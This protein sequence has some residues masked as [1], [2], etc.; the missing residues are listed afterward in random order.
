M[1]ICPNK[2]TPNWRALN[3]LVPDLSYHIWNKLE[4]N[5]DEKGHPIANNELFERIL[6][7]N[8]G[9]YKQSY[10][11]FINQ[12]IPNINYQFKAV[13][14]IL[15]NLN[16][17]ENWSKQIKDIDQLF[18]KIQK[19]LGIPKE[20]I[21]LIKQSE[22]KNI[23]EKLLDFISKYSYTVE[24]NL[25]TIG[26]NV[27]YNSLPKE[28]DYA[29]KH[30]YIENGKYYARRQS[31]EVVEI[32]RDF[33]EDEQE[34]WAEAN[35]TS[36]IQIPTQYYSNL[37]V[38]GG[39]NYTEN[40]ISTP[41]ITP[42]IKGHAQ[43][44]TGNGIGWFRS[45][46]RVKPNEIK[47]FEFKKGYYQVKEGSVIDYADIEDSIEDFEDGKIT[48]QQL[49]DRTGLSKHP[50]QFN[51]TL[52]WSKTGDST[53][54][55]RI[56][57]IQ[58][59][60]FQKGRDKES[61]IN[62]PYAPSN[63]GI[64]RSTIKEEL[65]EFDKE[66]GTSYTEQNQFLQLL[67][68]DNNWVTFFIKSIIQDSAKKGY[69]KVLFPKGETAAKVEGHQTIADEIIKINEEI[70]K[71]SKF[72]NN[73]SLEDINYFELGAFFYEK[74]KVGETYLYRTG[75]LALDEYDRNISKE[76]YEEA[77][78]D[79]NIRAGGV[80]NVEERIKELEQ[81]KAELKSQGIE[82]LKPIEA[83]YEIRVQNILKKLGNTKD[84]TDEYGN[85]WIEY[86]LS[87]E[88]LK[89]IKFRGL[90]K[91][92]LLRNIS[93]RIVD[94]AEVDL[95]KSTDKV[96]DELIQLNPDLKELLSKIKQKALDKNLKIEQEDRIRNGAQAA[97]IPDFNL[98]QT[99][100]PSSDNILH[101]L[102]H[103]IT[104]ESWLANPHS[105]YW[106]EVGK[107]YEYSLLKHP[108]LKDNY[109]FTDLEEF[110]SEV[111]ANPYLQKDLLNTELK[112]DYNTLTPTV[113]KHLNVLDRLFAM[114]SR[115]VHKFLD[116]KHD[117]QK[118]NVYRT[119]ID[120]TTKQFAEYNLDISPDRLRDNIKFRSLSES[121]KALT[122]S[123]SELDR[124]AQL[125]EKAI[126]AAR[127]KLVIEQEVY[128][129][130]FNEE[131][132]SART[133]FIEKMEK[134]ESELALITYT[135]KAY[136]QTKSVYSKYESVVKQLADI[137]SGKSKLLRKDIFNPA[138]L[139]KWRDYLAAY[140]VIDEFQSQLMREGRLDK[141]PDVKKLLEETIR[142]KNFI[143]DLYRIEGVNMNAEFQVKYY[144]QHRVDLENT[145][146]MEYS[147]LPQDQKDKISEQEFI[148]AKSEFSKESI[149]D[150]TKKNLRQESIRA[151]KDINIITRYVSSP[152][153]SKNPIVASAA[154]AMSIQ[155]FKTESE[156]LEA[157]DTIV[158][159][160]RELE[161]QHGPTKNKKK[162]YEHMIELDSNNKPTGN[163]INKFGGDFWSAYNKFKD[164]LSEQNLSNKEFRDNMRGW[165]NQN[166][167]LKNKEFNKARW[168]FIDNLKE[169]GKLSDEE[170]KTLEW[171]D[172]DKQ[173]STMQ[174]LSEA[175]LLN[176]DA[177]DLISEW[178]G[179]NIWEFREPSQ[180]WKNKNPQWNKLSQILKDS[181]DPR[182]KY[183]NMFL[184]QIEKYNDKLP[185]NKRLSPYQIPS[186]IRTT[187]DEIA[188]GESFKKIAGDIIHKNL[189]IFV[190]DPDRP[191]QTIIDEQGN[192]RNLIPIRYT[193]R[194]SK[195]IILDETGKEV[196]SFRTK[197]SAD[198]YLN[199]NINKKYKLQIISTPEE[200]SYDLSTVLM[201]FAHMAN[202]YANKKEVLAEMELT[203]FLIDNMEVVD[204]DTKGNPKQD[205]YGRIALKKKESIHLAN[206]FNDWYEMAMY[207]IREKDQGKVN[208]LGLN[209]D[210]N[211]ATSLLNRITSLNVLG[212]NLRAA[213][214]ITTLVE[215]LQIGEA[216]A[217]QYMNLKSYHKGNMF[218]TKN[219]PGLIADVGSRK[220][221]NIVN[222]LY[223]N[224]HLPSEPINTNF[225]DAT[226]F[227]R[228]AKTSSLFFIM[229]AGYFTA[230]SRLFLGMLEDKRAYNSKG[231]DIGSMLSKYSVNKDTE[232][233]EL[234]K[235]V[236]LVKSNWT[237]KEQNDFSLRTRAMIGGV[238]GE[239]GELE[240]SALQRLALGKLAIMFRKFIEP[241]VRKRYEKFGYNN[242]MRDYTEG[243]YRTT[244]KF[245]INLAK[246][247]RTLQ[248]SVAGEEWD[249]LTPY[250]KGNIIKTAS[251]VGFMLASI[252]LSGVFL[253]K[254]KEKDDNEMLYSWAAYQMLRFKS[255]LFFFSPK[256]D[257]TLSILRSPMASMSIAETLARTCY[258]LGNPTEE[259]KTGYW[260]G[261]LKL[262]KIMW[263]WIPGARSFYSMI[264]T[265]SQLNLMNQSLVHR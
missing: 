125:K 257:E 206:Y 220:P 227:S 147:Q 119:M 7:E 159:A 228:L 205:K 262:E 175:N 93:N 123:L 122:E 49:L 107:L 75:H 105:N 256:I 98:I 31:G 203:K 65:P 163:I 174:E 92:E 207:G 79:K 99:I 189:D 144:D 223:E 173:S 155:T 101:E 168:E 169:Q 232:K 57:E 72:K 253:R 244:G 202:D 67:N 201:K 246:E 74:V 34:R 113:N 252:I 199:K 77:K 241:G 157:R 8:G 177:A 37:T 76:E 211:K 104:R 18:D 63:A 158:D 218:F 95:S 51:N 1:L 190:D 80:N 193:K 243:Y 136:T 254:S 233:L 46:E 117:Y 214:N 131:E 132:L 259:Y 14:P 121:E 30:Y 126:K 35:K 120:L 26:K 171:N 137:D 186:V 86:N 208:L 134:Q 41:L 162:L 103:F 261:H 234:S 90:T 154:K 210:I 143:K 94:F 38:P 32:D 106:K 4:G 195:Y 139:A 221:I 235:D 45:D 85:E 151:F 129:K 212:L 25:K 239:Y 224:F 251:E 192:T 176:D 209:I 44:S 58:S 3:R 23:N 183:Y 231:E 42:S 33:F 170:Y 10:I 71:L 225:K 43:F 68:K 69:E 185:Y 59:D 110:V 197:S 146:R 17:I 161:K 89:D 247:L 127:T 238:H 130:K 13:Q 160:L 62:N 5:I 116:I 12:T 236:D 226:I 87:D 53:K 165:Y 100:E 6:E 167:P 179:G 84:I 182:T 142:D 200:Q 172:V 48:E 180:E 88:D 97:Y 70:N 56:L 191:N 112:E 114:L 66:L 164:G 91:D 81:R 20:Q 15:D 265:K 39:T 198:S 40:E 9:N 11:D 27:D 255:E 60:L 156:D 83:F 61:F 217:G 108:E 216:F 24:V 213:V 145:T 237:Q 128:G 22:G 73:K 230:Q 258:Q 2:N 102:G 135:Q 16:K 264:D 152:M 82:K 141:L 19:D 181:N 118:E 204:T 240:R 29:A 140:D 55:R 188:D 222:Q 109:A 54:T 229:N 153:S 219:I 194:L 178:I 96:I 242:R 21:D 149:D 245:L 250:E 248:F 28:F 187:S 215:A 115:L 47:V 138:L 36:G 166:A 64:D 50:K 184:D 124:M 196:T 52:Q 78:F 133:A 150:I 111:L 249:K 263:D 148:R 260:K